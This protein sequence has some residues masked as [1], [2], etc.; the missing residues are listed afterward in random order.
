MT[1]SS[2]NGSSSDRT[3]R[4]E[5][6]TG[7]QHRSIMRERWLAVGLVRFVAVGNRGR[8]APGSQSS[9]GFNTK[10]LSISYGGEV[11]TA[12]TAKKDV[13]ADAGPRTAPPPRALL[14]MLSVCQSNRG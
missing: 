7:W 2:F 14:D 8:V 6:V 4:I 1:R 10:S 9:S 13:R 11:V 3:G 5:V 12:L